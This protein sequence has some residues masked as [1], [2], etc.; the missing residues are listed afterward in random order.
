[1]K[2]ALAAFSHREGN[3]RRSKP[4]RV[5]ARMWETGEPGTRTKIKLMSGKGGENVGRGKNLC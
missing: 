5:S 3:T 2:E 4:N 1:V